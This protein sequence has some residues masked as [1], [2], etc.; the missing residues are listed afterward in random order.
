MSLRPNRRRPLLINQ[1]E[2]RA[3]GRRRCAQLTERYLG[4][5]FHIGREG[6]VRFVIVASY[7]TLSSNRLG[8]QAATTIFLEYPSHFWTGVSYD[9]S[10]TVITSIR[11]IDQRWSPRFPSTTRLRPATR[12]SRLPPRCPLKS[13]SASITRDMYALISC[14]C[15]ILT[16]GLLTDLVCSFISQQVPIISH[17]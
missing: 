13:C 15:R 7:I 11:S 1:R 10:L 9:S 17:T 6:I 14:S 5:V 3:P 16:P 8:S 12:T 4:S 2:L